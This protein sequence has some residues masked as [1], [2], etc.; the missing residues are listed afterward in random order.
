MSST[1]FSTFTLFVKNAAKG[2]GTMKLLVTAMMITSFFAATTSA[3]SSMA[4]STLWGIYGTHDVLACP[5]NNLETAKRVIAVGSRDN[6]PL[7][8][9]YGVTAILDRYHSALEHTF[10]WAVETTEPH[11]LEEFAIELGIAR[12]N[13]LTFVPLITFEEGVVPTLRRLHGLEDTKKN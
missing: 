10:L 12:F 7:M 5:I 11:N 8:K 2:F 6:R 1:Q 3:Q 13:K 9:K 4:K